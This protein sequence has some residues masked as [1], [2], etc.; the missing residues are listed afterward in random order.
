MQSFY[1]I[2]I[3]SY[4]LRKMVREKKILPRSGDE[5]YGLKRLLWYLNSGRKRSYEI[6]SRPDREERNLKRPDFICKDQMTGA[7]IT[8]EITQILNHPDR[9]EAREHRERIWYE[10]EI[11]R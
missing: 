5:E 6:V 8:V 9:L 4:E 11:G 1:D 3:K 10:T 7:E 2:Q